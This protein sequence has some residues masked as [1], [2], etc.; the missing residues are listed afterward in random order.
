MQ[1][2]I[3]S[4]ALLLALAAPAWA[5]A[6]KAGLADPEANIVEELVVVARDRGPAWWRVSDDDTTVYIL[7]TPE[8]SLP[9]DL[10]WDQ[11][12]L[13]R[14]LRGANALVGGGQSYKMS[15]SFK[16]LGLLLSLRRSLRQKGTMEDDLA[17][18]L[19]GRFVAA[20]TALGKD[21][22]HYAGWGPMVAGMILVRDTRGAGGSRWR[23]PQ[24][25]ARKAARTLQVRE[26]EM[27]K[28]DAAPVL[29][30]FKAGLT[31]EIQTAC[32]SAA[33]DDVEAGDAPAAESARGWARGDVGAALKAP[34]GIEKCFLAVA[35]GP[36]VWKQGI[37]DQAGAIAAELKRPGKAVAMV[38]LRQLIAKDGVIERL[39][40]MG[41]EV[42]GPAER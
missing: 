17:E 41:Y 40:A 21:E 11:S 20:R 14:R 6:P 39:E 34:R 7:G 23:D 26:R 4:A 3:G 16:T 13:N 31:M 9:S 32:L 27:V 12:G 24:D 25:D 1:L 18:P 19:R 35:G 10:D 5:Q 2:R 29:Q 22:R 30:E 33:L 8:V 42:E 37:E 28:H 38:R 15:F 36:A